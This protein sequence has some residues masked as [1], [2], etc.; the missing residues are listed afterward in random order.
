LSSGLSFAGAGARAVG[1]GGIVDFLQTYLGNEVTVVRSVGGSQ[2]LASAWRRLGFDKLFGATSDES[3]PALTR[4]A[5]AIAAYRA[6][7]GRSTASVQE[8][9]SQD[10]SIPDTETLTPHIW[11]LAVEL[12]CKPVMLRNLQTLA[13]TRVKPPAVYL[14][15]D[16]SVPGTDLVLAVSRDGWPVLVREWPAQDDP[17][18][19]P[20]GWPEGLSEE[21]STQV[22]FIQPRYGVKPR[23]G[24]LRS[25]ELPGH[26]H[27]HYGRIGG[28]SPGGT[29]LILIRSPDRTGLGQSANDV[30]EVSSSKKLPDSQVVHAYLAGLHVRQEFAE[31]LAWPLR[32]PLKE[33]YPSAP[34][35]MLAAW[36]AL[37]LARQV[38]KDTNRLWPTVRTELQRVYE[39]TI[40]PPGASQ[41]LRTRLTQE[42]RAI[43]DIMRCD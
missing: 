19:M 35:Q 22:V 3:P 34:A 2:V 40:G 13:L 21:L 14:A 41:V 38:E 10:V 15:R 43:L 37:L 24:R 6:L 16:T 11:N 1:L 4:A 28:D 30:I 36:I 33:H 31:M 27:V 18:E 7:A 20:P 32:A 23:T 29:R 12:F 26:G 25:I 5:F 9:V 17:E 39:V 8:W 42:Q